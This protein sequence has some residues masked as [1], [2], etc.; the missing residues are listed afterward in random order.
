MNPVSRRDDFSRGY[1]GGS[2]TS[3]ARR[4]IAATAIG[5]VLQR[6]VERAS[7]HSDARGA[8]IGPMFPSGLR[9]FHAPYSHSRRRIAKRRMSHAR[10]PISRSQYLPNAA[11]GALG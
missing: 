11:I 6:E 3:R 7:T 5:P 1:L 10:D 9:L 2:S 4:D 8:C